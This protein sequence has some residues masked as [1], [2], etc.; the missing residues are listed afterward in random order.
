MAKKRVCKSNIGEWFGI[1]KNGHRTSVVLLEFTGK[2][3]EAT[4]VFSDSHFPDGRWGKWKAFRFNSRWN[5]ANGT[6][7]KIL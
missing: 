6:E 5:T 3:N 1:E 4:A 7:I 2:G